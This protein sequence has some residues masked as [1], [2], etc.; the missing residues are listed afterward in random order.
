MISRI[1][2]DIGGTFTD[3]VSISDRGELAVA[4]VSSNPDDL[5]GVVGEGLERLGAQRAGG[6]ATLLAD[7]EIVVHG[8]TIATNALIQ[9]NLARSGMI[10]T[11]GFRDLL[12]L[13]EGLK[14]E[15]YNPFAVPPT[16]LVP[17][18]LRLPVSER[19]GPH[20]E[21]VTPLDEADVA[22][23]IDT[24]QG[25]GV[26]TVSVCLLWSVVNPEHEKRVRT[27]IEAA[28]P[29]VPVYLSSQVSPRIREYPRY[30]TT[31][32]CAALDPKLKR[33]VESVE[34]NL[35]GLGY[36]GAI[37]YIQCNG[38]TTSRAMLEARPVAAL[39]SGPAAG[40]AASLFFGRGLGLG[41]GASNLITFDM[42]GTSLDVSLVHQGEIE[43]AKDLDVHGYRVSLPMVKVRTLGAG[44]GSIAWVDDSGMLR[45]GPR[46]AEAHPGPACYAR[47]GLEPTVTDANVVLGYFN[48]QHLLGGRMPIVP[49]LA[50]AALREHVAVPLGLDVQQAALAVYTVV[51]EN[52]ANAV[53]QSSTEQGY[54]LREFAL[55]CGGGCSAAHAARVAESA[56]IARVIIPRVSAALCSFGA[57]V[58]DVRHD[59]ATSYH[60]HFSSCDPAFVENAYRDMES[61][62]REDLAQEGFDPQHMRL[63]RQL[64][65]RY[66]GEL[67]E[68]T[69]AVGASEFTSDTLDTLN[70][71]FHRAHEQAYTFEDRASACEIMN[72]SLV[73]RGQRGERIETLRPVEP[74]DAVH[75]TPTV[76]RRDAVFAEGVLTVDIVPGDTI[77]LDTNLEG[78]VIIE[79]TTTTIVVPPGWRVRLD[80]CHAWV[81]QHTT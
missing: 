81:M 78:P 63:E 28:M 29:G 58:T 44:G 35:R 2:I 31:A 49:S 38:G 25:H 32:L 50:E 71:S 13:R 42:G 72:M 45:I 73:A 39:D 27:L 48:P 46:S 40:P 56:G 76:Q 3:F 1:G 19:I 5:H 37:R 43:T 68:L 10:C 67:G 20:G 41:L 52:M 21:I 23:A 33:Y 66:V 26:E 14:E 77:A 51:N 15:R 24:F 53:H 64:D 34:G 70:E 16:P 36:N 8:T 6:L 79:E 57:A 17:R 65:V 54:D 62:A 69:L 11:R 12:E 74:A 4:K 75:A 80:G 30:S 55:A 59:Y 22:R 9:G 60:A 47:G 18:W 7:T 61:R